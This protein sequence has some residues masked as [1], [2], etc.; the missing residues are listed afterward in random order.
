MFKNKSDNQTTNMSSNN[1]KPLETTFLGEDAL[2][3]GELSFKGTL[4]IDGKFTGQIK[5][6][7]MLI[8]SETGDID[9]DIEAGIVVCKGRV[10][11]N[12][13]ASQKIEMHS[14]SRVIGDVKTPS[15]NIEI[16]AILDGK[17]DMSPQENVAI[18]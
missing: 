14:K 10:K 13:L 7:D 8:V 16:G 11:G 15:I 18:R 2:F 6:C 5:T 4:C 1:M 17:C 9:A 3:K 12:I